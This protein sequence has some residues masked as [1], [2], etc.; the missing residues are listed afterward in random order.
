MKRSVRLIVFGLGGIVF[1]AFMIVAI[2]KVW[3]GHWLGQQITRLITS[4]LHKGRF[5]IG[6]IDPLWGGLRLR[7]IS[8]T[9]PEGVRVTIPTVVVK[10]NVLS[11]I[12]NRGET[13]FL[14]EVV[15]ETLSVVYEPGI[16]S[17]PAQSPVL[18]LSGDEER[19]STDLKAK[20]SLGLTRLNQRINKAVISLGRVLDLSESWRIANG[21]IAID[22]EGV[23]KEYWIQ[24]KIEWVVLLPLDPDERAKSILSAVCEG[25]EIPL[26]DDRFSLYWI[27]NPHRNLSQ[28]VVDFRLK[29]KEQVSLPWLNNARWSGGEV[30]G[31]GQINFGDSTLCWG[32]IKGEKITLQGGTVPLEFN[33]RVRSRGRSMEGEGDAIWGDLGSF[34]WEG[35]W[36]GMGDFSGE[37][38]IQGKSLNF[39]KIVAKLTGN[40]LIQGSGEGELEVKGGLDDI[41]G[42][43][44]VQSPHLTIDTLTIKAFQLK[45]QY[46]SGEVEVTECSGGVWEGDFNLSGFFTPKGKIWSFQGDYARNWERGSIPILGKYR[47]PVLLS[48]FQVSK[49]GEVW[50]GEG[51][52]VL[53]D[54]AQAETLLVADAE[55]K[56]SQAHLAVRPFS[57]PEGKLRIVVDLNQPLRFNLSG[58]HL[59]RFLSS[60]LQNRLP[61]FLTRNDYQLE[62]K[63]DLRGGDLALK[64]ID[65]L[66]SSNLK[67]EL[68][69]VRKNSGLW[70]GFIRGEKEVFSSSERVGFWG[71]G[72]VKGGGIFIE[73]VVLKSSSGGKGAVGRVETSLRGGGVN[74]QLFLTQFPLHLWLAVP[75]ISL[76]S[77]KQWLDGVITIKG[78]D[79]AGD[80]E[81]TLLLPDTSWW[82]GKTNVQVAPSEW[83]VSTL[84]LS[85]YGREKEGSLFSQLSVEGGGLRGDGNYQS[86]RFSFRHLPI[87]VIKFLPVQQ[88]FGEEGE[89][90]G[91]GFFSIGKDKV[92]A[93]NQISFNDVTFKGE[94]GFWGL[95]NVTSS[96]DSTFLTLNGKMGRGEKL[97]ANLAGMY[98]FHRDSLGIIFRFDSLALE[99]LN[100][101]FGGSFP[102]WQGQA[103][104]EVVI[105][106]DRKGLTEG[107]VIM[108]AHNGFIGP[109]PYDQLVVSLHIQNPGSSASS[110]EIE[111]FR[112]DLPGS[113]AFAMGGVKLGENDTWTVVLEVS[114]NLLKMVEALDPDFFSGAEGEGSM[115]VS[116]GGKG[117]KANLQWARLKLKKGGIKFADVLRTITDLSVEIEVDS[118]G[119]FRIRK[120]TGNVDGRPF[121][122]SNRPAKREEGEEGF[123]V[124]GIDLGVFQFATAGEGLHLIIPGLMLKN[125]SGFF[126]FRGKGGSGAF[127]FSGPLESPRG[128]GSIYLRQTMFTYPLLFP[129]GS[130]P[131]SPFVKDLLRFLE[132]TRWEVEI[133]PLRG[134][135]YL[136]TLSAGVGDIV[137]GGGLKQFWGG[138]W[139][140]LGVKLDL[141]VWLEDSP[142]GITLSGSLDD[143]LTITGEL[144]S[145]QGSIRLLDRSFAVREMSLRFIPPDLEPTLKGEAY[146]TIADSATGQ[147]REVRLRVEGREQ[148]VN[149]LSEIYLILENDRGD[150]PGEI[151]TQLGYTPEQ[152]PARLGLGQLLTVS[153]VISATKV[154]ERKLEEIFGL[155]LVELQLPLTRNIFQYRLYSRPS[156]TAKVSLSSYWA[157]LYGSRLTMGRYLTPRLFVSYSSV[158]AGEGWMTNTPRIGLIHSWD[159]IFRL[160]QLS[161]RFSLNLQYQYDSLSEETNARVFITYM[162]LFDLSRRLKWSSYKSLR[163]LFPSLGNKVS[164]S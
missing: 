15:A 42:N 107:M 22:V 79:I 23:R 138:E 1:C 111:Q 163:S 17:L 68:R 11:Y 20:V 24:S 153:P 54:R 156:D 55:I 75:A 143:T 6:S 92:V 114:G 71:K 106:G 121:F 48:H 152:L 100:P 56:R 66:D 101:L 63:G 131:P 4:E 32:E 28:S 60:T 103:R 47:E 126:T 128:K 130:K 120:F 105:R 95:V 39:G 86:W 35:R 70:E 142:R 50:K 36:G 89:L 58:E 162:H 144:S 65:L 98:H 99:E 149:R 57:S 76:L 123:Q 61:H 160:S 87:K 115:L 5:N 145:T 53:V 25:V 83:R 161:T 69:G 30:R 151:L 102:D 14:K 52:G 159:A 134:C 129:N 80:L 97:W 116:V 147:P 12:I 135:R 34:N 18:T 96:P 148:G 77:G 150:T 21:F 40:S 136:R 78:G 109:L 104:G 132:R 16:R 46:H 94:K 140:E 7:E 27:L 122:L 124:G 62:A 44:K 73:P 13:P 31:Y 117:G 19:L 74:G 154:L 137:R 26:K 64:A 110:W 119:H 118:L 3:G 85:E 10:G 82:K 51:K 146:T 49:R 67:L 29:Q 81:L 84:E 164:R 91:E 141:D 133:V 155:D 8:Y 37:L 157:T 158:F 113:R 9:T 43:L 88:V 33:F 139:V 127:E 108:T 112:L 125:W 59:Q 2:W 38:K 41:K 93:R 72:V 90:N 45:A